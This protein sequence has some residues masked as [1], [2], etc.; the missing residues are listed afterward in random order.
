VRL[1]L[2]TAFLLLVVLSDSGFAQLVK[3]HYDAISRAELIAP[4]DSRFPPV[5]DDILKAAGTNDSTNRFQHIAVVLQNK[6]KDPILGYAIRWEVVGPSGETSKV[7][8]IWWQRLALAA[9][10]GEADSGDPSKFRAAHMVQVVAAGASRLITPF[11]NLSRQ[12][13]VT[14]F[15]T[16]TFSGPASF[17]AQILG[18]AAMATASLTIKTRYS[19]LF[20]CGL[21]K[22][23]MASVNQRNC[24]HCRSEECFQLVWT[25]LFRAG[26]MNLETSSATE[27]RSIRPTLLKTLTWGKRR[28]TYF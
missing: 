1:F 17:P 13:D 15:G 9:V 5:R 28:L 24:I 21:M 12:S 3:V 7:N 25:I 4:G 20:V 14:S 11:F 27:P 19:L 2:G 8:Q 22:T 23:T 26:L 10:R 16:H 18:A 6:S